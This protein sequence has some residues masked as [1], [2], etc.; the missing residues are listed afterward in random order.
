MKEHFETYITNLIY[1]TFGF[2][3]I[4]RTEE[5]NNGVI[6]IFLD[7]TNEERK[8]MMGFHAQ[9]FHAIKQMLICF[10]KK[11]KVYVFLYLEF[12]NEANIPDY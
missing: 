10:S 7:G 12:Q 4:V 9:N 8:Q 1:D 5:P 6:K 11:Y 2:S 3:P